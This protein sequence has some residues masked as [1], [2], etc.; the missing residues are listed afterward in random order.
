VTLVVMKIIKAK[1]KI[2]AVGFMARDG[3]AS[4]KSW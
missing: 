1:A 3:A 2:R 4:A